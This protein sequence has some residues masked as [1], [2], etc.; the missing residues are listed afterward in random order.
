MLAVF[1]TWPRGKCPLSD[2]PGIPTL[3]E[4]A[5]LMDVP[6]ARVGVIDGTAHAPGQAW[7]HGRTTGED[8]VVANSRGNSRQ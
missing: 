7:K 5:G 3:V 1:A 8:A 2:L 4:K 6:Q